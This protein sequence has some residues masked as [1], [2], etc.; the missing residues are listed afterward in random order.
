M[1]R[2]AHVMET[3]PNDPTKT[4]T[5]EL[6]EEEYA[7]HEAVEEQMDLDDLIL[8]IFLVIAGLLMFFFLVKG[9]PKCGYKWNRLQRLNFASEEDRRNFYS[10]KA[11]TKISL[12]INC[13]RCKAVYVQAYPLRSLTGNPHQ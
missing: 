1:L 5:R 10:D 13:K 6:T 8:P 4:I 7:M 9:C 12:K 11:G 3:D 2:P